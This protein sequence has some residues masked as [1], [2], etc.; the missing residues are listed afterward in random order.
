MI[1]FHDDTNGNIFA[2]PDRTDPLDIL[3]V[4]SVFSLDVLI[5]NP[6]PT[7][8]LMGTDVG[9]FD[10]DNSD[11]TKFTDHVSSLWCMEKHGNCVSA[12]LSL[13]LA[14]KFTDSVPLTSDLE[15]DLEPDRSISKYLILM[16]SIYQLFCFFS[17]NEE[18]STIFSKIEEPSFD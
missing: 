12:P 11:A 15:P 4:Q 16:R 13:D 2:F 6:N 14:T 18:F 8:Y 9:V 17:K 10:Q 7:F 1:V 3:A 5:K